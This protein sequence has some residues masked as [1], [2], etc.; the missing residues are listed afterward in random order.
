MFG[1]DVR[2]DDWKIDLLCGG[3][4]KALSA[5]PGLTMVTLSADAKAAMENRKTPIASF[6][7]NLLTFKGY[8]EAKW[9]P[10]TMPASDIYGLRTALENVKADPQILER[11]A[12]VAAYTREAIA[13]ML[14]A[15]PGMRLLQHRNHLR[16]TGRTHRRRD[17]AQNALRPQHPLSR[18]LRLLRRKTDPYRAYG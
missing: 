2:V 9:F 4:Q 17:P 13:S 8:Y 1:E 11:H 6:Y 7:A 3:S 15:L 12:K 16:S 5:P 14:T 18:L 10:Y